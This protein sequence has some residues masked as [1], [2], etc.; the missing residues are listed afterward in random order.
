MTISFNPMVS[1]NRN[2]IQKQNFGKIP[3][4]KVIEMFDEVGFKPSPKRLQEIK[5]IVERELKDNTNTPGAKM[6]LE[7]L[8]IHL[9]IKKK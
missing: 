9:G 3:E 5:E 6:E 4:I 1:N 8:A 2:K 7:S